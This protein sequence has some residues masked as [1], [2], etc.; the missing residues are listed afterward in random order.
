MVASVE[1]RVRAIAIVGFVG[2][3]ELIVRVRERR[4]VDGSLET[5]LER[6]ETRNEKRFESFVRRQVRTARMGCRGHTSTYNAHKHLHQTFQTVRERRE[7]RRRL[8][9]DLR[10]SIHRHEDPC[11]V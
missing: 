7:K 3:A 9:K 10:H 11:R 8:G 5:R 6:V 4:R 2:P 1:I